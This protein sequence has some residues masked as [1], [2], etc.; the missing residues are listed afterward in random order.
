[1]IKFVLTIFCL[2]IL[3]KNNETITL[4]KLLKNIIISFYLMLYFPYFC[5]QIIMPRWISML[6]NLCPTNVHY[7]ALSGLRDL[8]LIVSSPPCSMCC[9]LNHINLPGHHLPQLENDAQLPCP[10]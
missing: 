3:A 2:K 10:S 6:L 9:W 8:H 7:I 5:M 4:S 1:M